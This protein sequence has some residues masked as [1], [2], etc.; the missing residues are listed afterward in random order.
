MNYIWFLLFKTD[1]HAST[2]KCMSGQFMTSRICLLK[3]QWKIYGQKN[4]QE[5]YREN[6]NTRVGHI[7]PPILYNNESKKTYS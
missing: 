6:I 5:E 3:I 1:E 2:I 4:G 7:F